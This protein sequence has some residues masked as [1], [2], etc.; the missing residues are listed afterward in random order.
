MVGCSVFE[1]VAEVFL[2]KTVAL[3]EVWVGRRLITGN[4]RHGIYLLLM[5]P[6]EA[7]ILVV[8]LPSIIRAVKNFLMEKEDDEN[9]TYN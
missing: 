1:C 2:L 3:D 4:W 7:L 9:G 5:Y 8:F 6:L